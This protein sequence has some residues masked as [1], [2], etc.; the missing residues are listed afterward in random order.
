MLYYSRQ[1]KRHMDKK[2]AARMTAV[3]QL[4][5][6][7][8]LV[9]N[10]EEHTIVGNSAATRNRNRAATTAT[11]SSAFL[12]AEDARMHHRT[13]TGSSADVTAFDTH[14]GHPLAAPRAPGGS[15]TPTSPQVP[16]GG[17]AF[18]FT[19]QD[20]T[21]TA[22]T[23]G[24]AD[25]DTGSAQTSRRGSSVS[26]AQV[27]EMLDDSVWMASIRRSATMRRSQSI[28]GSQGYGH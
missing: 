13:W 6:P 5:V 4:D 20:P 8:I 22:A 7:E 21:D 3:P 16:P 17:S 10:E 11:S 15:L 24:G 12:S 9:E 14:I 25:G 1:F 2:R 19:L 27:R 18:S 26:P 28:W 23:A